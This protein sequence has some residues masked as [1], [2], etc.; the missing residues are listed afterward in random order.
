GREQ[1]RAD[2]DCRRGDPQVTGVA[3][4]VE[5]VTSEPARVAKVC[6]GAEQA[7]ADRN[8]GGRLDG[9]L[10]SLAARLTPL[11][12][13]RAVAELAHGYCGQEDLKPGH[14]RDMRFQTGASA[15]AQRS[16]EDAGVDDDPH[17]WTA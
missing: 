4:V 2:V 3:A 8:H 16:A 13:E 7:V 10:E 12:D 9:R 15:T 11:C 5:R 17:S 1:W 6:D 14:Q